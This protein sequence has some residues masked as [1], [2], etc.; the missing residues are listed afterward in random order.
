MIRKINI[1]TSVFILSVFLACNNG[2]KV[3]SAKS[4]DTTERVS[5]GIFSE[6][7]TADNTFDSSNNNTGSFTE[8]LHTV[9]AKE[10]LPTEKYVYVKV[11]EGRKEFWIAAIKQEIDLGKV[12]YYRNDLLK[13][14]F[15]SKEYNRVFDTIYLV[16][17][18]VS[19]NHGAGNL[20]ADFTE[21]PKVVKSQKQDIPTHTEE[22]IEHKGSTKIAEIVANPQKYAGK[23]VQVT[24]KCV[25]V[26]PNIMNRNWI[27]LQ[28]GSKDDFD[29]VVTSNTF[30][31]EGQ[32]VTMKAEVSLNRD[33]GAGY[34]YNLILENGI[35]VE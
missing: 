30:V 35:V 1:I 32:I 21:E 13:T 31:P 5:S 19:H 12:Y 6:E 17:N 9:V 29:F 28:D 8:N 23:T 15:E 10:V 33:F 11:T 4:S 7:D 20:K 25:K 16:S 24:G 27:H 34:S 26:N 18:L 14:N 3:I 22:I 2:P